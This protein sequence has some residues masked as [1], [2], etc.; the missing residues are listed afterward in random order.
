M[1]W[2]KRRIS[3]GKQDARAGFKPFML[4]GL[5]TRSKSCGCTSTSMSPEGRAPMPHNTTC[6]AAL[7]EE[8]SE[9]LPACPAAPATARA[10]YDCARLTGKLGSNPLP[11]AV[12]PGLRR[13]CSPR[14]IAGCRELAEAVP[15]EAGLATRARASRGD[16]EKGRSPVGRVRVVRKGRCERSSCAE[17]FRRVAVQLLNE[18]LARALGCAKQTRCACKQLRDAP[19]RRGCGLVTA[20][21]PAPSVDITPRFSQG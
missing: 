17:R 8:T 11:S 20:S 5:G 15:A 16:F 6:S 12:Q 19:M 3:G 10:T 14:P 7:S 2:V 21:S 9:C 13:Q 4:H 18:A 1:W